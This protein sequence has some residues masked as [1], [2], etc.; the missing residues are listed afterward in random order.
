MKCPRCGSPHVTQRHA[1]RIACDK[2]GALLGAAFGAASAMRGARL[3]LRL[4]S[5]FGPPAAAAGGIAGAV[6]TGVFTGSAVS[7]LTSAVGHLFDR[8]VLNDRECQDCA[9]VFRAADASFEA[10]QRPETAVPQSPVSAAGS[11]SV[12]TPEAS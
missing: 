9:H 1:G 11:T 6:V 5:V 7:A 10:A 12:L 3:G 8:E 2:I 4:G